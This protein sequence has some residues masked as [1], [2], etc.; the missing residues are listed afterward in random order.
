MLWHALGIPFRL[1]HRTGGVADRRQ[2]SGAIQL[3]DGGVR[4]G[5]SAIAIGEKET[6]QTQRVVLVAVG[7]EDVIDVG[8]R[9]VV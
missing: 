2:V 1:Q 7:D 3:Q 8:G 6:W 5:L 9:H 4:P